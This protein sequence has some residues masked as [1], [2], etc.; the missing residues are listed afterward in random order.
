MPL[1]KIRKSFEK[2]KLN[3]VETL[4]ENEGE[5]ELSK[6]HQIYGAVKEIEKVL[7]IIDK[8][9]QNPEEDL[10]VELEGKKST[11]E[12]SPFLAKAGLAVHKAGKV[13]AKTVAGATIA[14]GKGMKKAVKGTIKGTKNKISN[15]KEKI[16]LYKQAV[17]E[18]KKREETEIEERVYKEKRTDSKQN[19]EEADQERRISY[20]E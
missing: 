20:R 4:K 11:E 7:N 1:N 6:Q 16:D 18:I 3:L 2:R 9:K 12:T 8:H 10:E 19:M 5:L 14:L 13:G 17:E 15:T